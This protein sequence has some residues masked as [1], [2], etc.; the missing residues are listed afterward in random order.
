MFCDMLQLCHILRK[1]EC[2]NVFIFV[3]YRCTKSLKEITIALSNDCSH[4]TI[5]FKCYEGISKG[6]SVWMTLRRHGG[7]VLLL[8]W[9]TS[10]LPK[11]GRQGTY[12][13]SVEMHVTKFC[14]LWLL[15]S[16]NEDQKMCGIVPEDAKIFHIVTVKESR[17]FELIG[18][19]DH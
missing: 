6:K 10:L 16:L 17:Q 18:Y 2:W 4:R 7:H 19:H 15:G 5:L 13:Q 9:K 1:E 8:R 3:H 14:C 11:A 12:R